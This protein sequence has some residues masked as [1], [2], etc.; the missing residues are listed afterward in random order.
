MNEKV[1]VSVIIPVYNVEK[2]LDRCVQSVLNQTLKEIEVILVDDGSPD[3]CPQLCDEY[4]KMDNRVKVIHKENQGLG[5]ARNS[6]MEIA[7][8]EYIAFVDSDDWIKVDMYEKL[9]RIGMKNNSD[10]VVGGH[11]DFVNNNPVITKIHPLARKIYK[12]KK[13]ILEIR[14]NL[15]GH[16]P[17][18]KTIEAF[19]MSSCMSLY[20]KSFINENNLRFYKGISEDTIFNL[21]A[22]KD[23][24]SITFTEY[25]DYCYRKEGQNSITQTFSSDKILKY[26]QFLEKLFEIAYMEEN[27]ENVIRVKKTAIDYS[28][29]YVGILENSKLSL[30]EKKKYIEKFIDEMGHFWRDYPIKKLPMQQKIFQILI[31][32]KY[33]FLVLLLSKVRKLLKK[34]KLKI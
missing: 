18:D 9:Y 19:P 12:E 3:N 8:G 30:K 5:F 28:R 17:D 14:K 22:Y 25:T 31:E 10:I 7:T 4:V 23:A 11:S 27:E 33:Y 20:K 24:N 1:K 6:G 34:K 29:L 15:F 2:Y 16:A 32:K 26:K 21:D 13:E